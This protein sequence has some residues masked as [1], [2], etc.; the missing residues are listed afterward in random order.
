MVPRIRSRWSPRIRSIPTNLADLSGS[1]AIN[2]SVVNVPSMSPV[3]VLVTEAR[4]SF[5]TPTASS[6]GF[7]SHE[8]LRCLEQIGHVRERRCV[9][10]Q[11]L[12]RREAADRATFA[13]EV[14]LVA[15]ASIDCE[16]AERGRATGTPP[17]RT[18]RQ[19]PLQT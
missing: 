16:L 13:G 10:A 17:R 7:S 5:A 4:V 14:G 18:D 12:D 19:E 15:V 11:Q 6:K 8:A 3:Y 1:Y 2:H 9:L